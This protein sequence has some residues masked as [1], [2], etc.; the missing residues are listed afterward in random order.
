M[1]WFDIMA[2]GDREQPLWLYAVALA[3]TVGMGLLRISHNASTSR[4]QEMLARQQLAAQEQLQAITGLRDLCNAQQMAID[5]LREGIALLEAR[6]AARE[7]ENRS[8]RATVA[9]LKRTVEALRQRL[10]QGDATDCEPTV[11]GALVA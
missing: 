2:G 8:L 7:T 5:Q 10:S 6:V 9:A 11:C 3:A 1:H 4:V